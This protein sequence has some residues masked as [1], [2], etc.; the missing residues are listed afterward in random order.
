MITRPMSLPLSSSTLKY[1]LVFLQVLLASLFIATSAQISIPLYFTPIPL[2]G[3]TLAVLLVGACLGK[4]KGALSVLLYLVEGVLG[5]PV[6]SGGSFGLLSLLGPK[7]GY[8]IGFVAQSYLVGWGLE[9]SRTSIGILSTLLFASTVQMSLGV[10]WLSQFTG[11]T[12]S[13]H[14]GFTPFIAGEILKSFLV[15]FYLKREKN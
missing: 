9:K 14:L 12:L 1:S 7:G 5:L 11:F 4:E 10:L 13:L 15:F 6:F 3:Q 8:L 2:T